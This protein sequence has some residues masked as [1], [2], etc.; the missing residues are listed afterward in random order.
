LSKAYVATN[1]FYSF[2]GT[3]VSNYNVVC[4]TILAILLLSNLIF[5]YITSSNTFSYKFILLYASHT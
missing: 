5:E 2:V 1:T 3:R 4:Q